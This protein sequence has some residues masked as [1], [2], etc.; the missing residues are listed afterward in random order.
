MRYQAVVATL[1]LLFTWSI[2]ASAQDQGGYYGG[3]GSDTGGQDQGGYYDPGQGYQDP[4]QGYGTQPQPQPQPAAQPATQPSSGA[5]FAVSTEGATAEADG[6]EQISGF[7]LGINWGGGTKVAIEP[8]WCFGRVGLYVLAGLGLQKLHEEASTDDTTL[9]D[10]TDPSA[11][12]AHHPGFGDWDEEVLI[13]TLGLNYSVGLA[14]RVYLLEVLTTRSTNLY[15]ELGAGWRGAAYKTEVDWNHNGDE[16]TVG[17]INGDGDVDNQ[18]IEDYEYGVNMLANQVAEDINDDAEEMYD[19]VWW[20]L[21]IGGEY[22]FPGGFGI[23]GEAGL[24]F[25][26]NTPFTPKAPFGYDDDG[27]WDDF[28]WEY[29]DVTYKGWVFEFGLYWAVALRYHF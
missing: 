10:P 14:F 28:D 21:G 3:G 13:E 18:D 19:G 9:N 1:A 4:G 25:F 20:N 16:E 23:A 17:D 2:A 7:E 24:S 12:A 15:L 5:G 22:V 11:G 27:D 8:G 26:M 29:E 6:G